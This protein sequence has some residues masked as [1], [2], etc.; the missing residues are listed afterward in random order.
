M[1]RAGLST[2]AV[3][4][5]AAQL[6]DDGMTDG[7]NLAALA[8]SFGVRVP[9]LYKHI[10]GMPGLHRAITVRAK[11][12]LA[13]TL[14]RAAIGRSR[15]DAIT[16]MSFAYRHW[17]LEH[18]GQYLMTMRAPIPGDGDDL[19]ASSSIVDVVYNVL[20]G[21]DL[22]GDDAVDATRF[23]RSSL[24]GFVALETGGAFELPA[25]LE[26]SFVRLVESVVTALAAWS[27]S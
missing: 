16:S 9:S 25:D 8:E 2:S 3:V 17:A 21:Y 20:A 11:S 23:L 26:R 4:E 19:E 1:V 18:P 13:V 22:R 7:L 15:G 10:D 24:H 6:L 5:R 14:G 27:R 12:N